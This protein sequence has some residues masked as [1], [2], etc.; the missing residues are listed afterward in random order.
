MD[1]VAADPN[2]GFAGVV[3]DDKI[4]VPQRVRKGG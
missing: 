2:E 3:A 1:R 4:F